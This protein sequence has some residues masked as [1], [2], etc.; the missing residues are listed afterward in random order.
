MLGE[1]VELIVHNGGKQT[2]QVQRTSG[3]LSIR[4]RV[5]VPHL[6]IKDESGKVHYRIAEKPIV[7]LD[8]YLHIVDLP[9]KMRG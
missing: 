7:P 2:R 5:Q 9:V 3:K 8:E 4:R 1:G 6:L